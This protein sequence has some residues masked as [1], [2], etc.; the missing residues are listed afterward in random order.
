[1]FERSLEAASPEAAC[2]LAPE[3]A[4]KSILSSPTHQ[5]VRSNNS[6]ERADNCDPAMPV[7]IH[8]AISGSILTTGS[9]QSGSLRCLALLFEPNRSG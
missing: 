7:R 4:A 8:Q 9:G 6:D 2:C 3:Q 1:M 5:G